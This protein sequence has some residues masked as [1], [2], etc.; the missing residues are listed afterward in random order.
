M[1]RNNKVLFVGRSLSRNFISSTRKSFTFHKPANKNYS[2]KWN[3]KYGTGYYEEQEVAINVEEEL[4]AM[5]TEFPPYFRNT[6]YTPSGI[7]KILLYA[8]PFVLSGTAGLIYLNHYIRKDNNLTKIIE[9]DFLSVML[10]EFKHR[11]DTKIYQA[12]NATMSV[13]GYIC[14]VTF[15]CAAYCRFRTRNRFNGFLL[16][17][18]P[19]YV[20]PGESIVRREV[21]RPAMYTGLLIGLGIG[22][23][24]SIVAPVERV[25][26]SQ[27][28]QALLD[29]KGEAEVLKALPDRSSADLK[30]LLFSAAAFTSYVFLTMIQPYLLAPTFAAWLWWNRT[31]F[32][33]AR[34]EPLTLGSIL[35]KSQP[36]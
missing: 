18:F 6:H 9:D 36:Q 2:K 30:I 13:L 23:I 31:I 25:M 35:E 10:L 17:H 33:T 4:Q 11:K 3:R 5:R 27:A 32:P 15:F 16:S 22:T 26:S 20:G 7:P 12:A 21:S 28:A 29:G 24:L 34:K 8:S 19:I 14:L 1:R